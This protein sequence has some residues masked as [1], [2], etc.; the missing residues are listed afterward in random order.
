MWMSEIWMWI[1][2][3]EKNIKTPRKT[4]TN[5]LAKGGPFFTFGLPGGDSTL[6]LGVGSKGPGNPP[7][8]RITAEASLQSYTIGF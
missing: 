6:A 3:T 4:K 2:Y 8:P 5:N 7:E 1:R